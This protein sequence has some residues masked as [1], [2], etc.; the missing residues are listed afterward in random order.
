[1]PSTLNGESLWISADERY[2]CTLSVKAD[3]MKGLINQYSGV[4]SM[5]MIHPSVYHKHCSIYTEHEQCQQELHL[6]SCL[7]SDFHD[8]P[9]VQVYILL[10]FEES[11]MHLLCTAYKEPIMILTIRILSVVID[12][13]SGS[14]D[15]QKVQH[16]VTVQITTS[17]SAC[18]KTH[19]NCS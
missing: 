4:P 7:M 9:Q 6:A 13:L 5:S 11:L 15:P 12:A 1:M 8:S 16:I 3:V 10:G 14:K 19:S 17:S 18:L 2:I